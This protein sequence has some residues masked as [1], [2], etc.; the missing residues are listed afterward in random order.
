[1]YSF[2]CD[3]ALQYLLDESLE[4]I[5]FGFSYLSDFIQ[6]RPKDKVF[7]CVSIHGDPKTKK[8]WSYIEYFG[9]FRV[10]VLLSENYGGEYKNEMYS[11][12][13]INGS[14]V[15]VKVRSD[16]DL[17]ELALIWSGSGYN[18]EIYKSA[19]D[20]A[21]PVIMERCRSRTLERYIREGFY[22][23]GKQLGL[24]EGDEIPKEKAAEFTALMMEKLSPYI[25]HLVMRS[26]RSEQE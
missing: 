19:M 25:H 4:A 26:R 6:N 3:K 11:V 7:H 14:A 17:E 20:Y 9:I 15:G 8:L 5:P 12:D 21:M 23:A 18:P 13:P 2:K 10:V 22:Y 1:M 16:V 24:K